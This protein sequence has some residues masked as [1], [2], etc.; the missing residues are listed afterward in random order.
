MC[1]KL[2]QNYNFSLHTQKYKLKTIITKIFYVLYKAKNWRQLGDGWNNIYKHFIKL[3]KF[4][5][6]EKTYFD[7]LKKYLTTNKKS[8]KLVSIDTTIVYNKFGIDQLKRN[9]Y[10][11]NK[12]CYKLFTMIDS[13][14][15]PIYFSY[16]TGNTNDNKIF[17]INL[18]KILNILDRKCKIFLADSGFCSKLARTKLKKNNICPLIPKNIRGTKKNFK[19]KELTYQERLDIMFEDFSDSER[20][21]YKKRIEVE[22]FYSN[23]KQIHRLNLRYDKYYIN[24]IGF[25]YIYLSKLLI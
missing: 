19:M 24:L 25:I 13:K 6:F 23:Y 15:K 5:F 10:A 14:R 2:K 22:N 11:K 16:H 20:I 21:I 4:K 3:N 8:L 1:S 7:L 17:R 12:K 9:A 18:N